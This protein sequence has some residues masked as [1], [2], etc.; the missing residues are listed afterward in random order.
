MGDEKRKSPSKKGKENSPKKENID[1][2][3]VV[4]LPEV[5]SKKVDSKEK[6]GS[7]NDDTKQTKKRAVEKP[8]Q[9]QDKEEVYNIEALVEKKGSKYL[10]QWENFPVDHNTWEPRSSI[11]DFILQVVKYPHLFPL[12]NIFLS[13]VL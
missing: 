12:Q 6:P 4:K 8:N 5:E 9:M 3:E 10:V 2:Q 1:V 11:P 7:L 13:L